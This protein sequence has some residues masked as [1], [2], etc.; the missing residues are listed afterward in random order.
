MDENEII[1]PEEY[2]EAVLKRAA[3]TGLS[4]EELMEKMI[5][6]YLDKRGEP[7]GE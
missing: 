4:V 3:E 6:D 1:I 2:V 7:D 5:R